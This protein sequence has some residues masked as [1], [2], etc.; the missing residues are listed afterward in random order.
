LVGMSQGARVALHFSVEHPE[1]VAGVI[2]QGAPLSGFQPAPSGEDIIPLA[3]YA[4]L[5][6]AGKIAE[7]RAL[8]RDHRLMRVDQAQAR[9]T[10]DDMLARYD[11]RDLMVP[12]CGPLR[13][14]AAELATISVPVLVVTGERDTPWRRL[15]ADALSYGLPSASREVIGNAGH[16]CNLTHA[17]A[18]NEVV[19]S[20]VRRIE[21][22]TA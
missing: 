13:P 4:S 2:L 18:Y 14:L 15:V 6:R 7:M 16:L 5:V 11:G 1:R 22:G 9:H 21:A 17:T 12:P 10:L 8:W 3:D 19:T 20:F